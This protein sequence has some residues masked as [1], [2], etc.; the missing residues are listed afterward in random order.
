M[1]FEVNRTSKEIN[2]VQK[3]IGAKKKV[4]A[5]I[6]TL[7]D[8]LIRNQAKENADELVAKKKELDALK[9]QKLKDAKDFEILMRQKASTVGNIV[10]PGAPVSLT[11][12]DNK[13][14]RTWHPEGPNVQV[15]KRTD[16][17]P[18]HEVLLRLDAMDLERGMLCST[19]HLFPRLMQH[20]REDCW[21]SWFLPNG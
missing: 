17:M 18:H 9:E 12:D 19:Y 16:I 13:T 2:A 4:C 7:F 8:W 6:Y 10:G 20:R 3:D 15:E 1:D 5:A 11:E 21:P 14:L